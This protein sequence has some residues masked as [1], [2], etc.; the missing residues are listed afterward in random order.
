M[1]KTR[2]DPEDFS[3]PLRRVLVGL[4]VLVLLGLFL[5]W[6]IDSPRV[7]RYRAALVDRWCRLLTG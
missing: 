2:T 5:L 4:L 7:E 3:R 1:A 6:R